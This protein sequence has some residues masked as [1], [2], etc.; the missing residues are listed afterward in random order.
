[1]LKHKK[2]IYIAVIAILSVLLLN[3]FSLNIFLLFNG[4]SPFKYKILKESSVCVFLQDN[5]EYTNKKGKIILVNKN[6]YNYCI[7]VTQK[8]YLPLWI[9]LSTKGKLSN[10]QDTYYSSFT[11]T[12]LTQYYDLDKQKYIPTYLI[13]KTFAINDNVECNNKLNQNIKTIICKRD[14]ITFIDL[15]SLFSSDVHNEIINMK[16]SDIIRQ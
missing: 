11:W 1:M 12:E 6:G 2:K 5:V 13:H 8:K 7:L 10:Q 3:I 4:Y 9:D 16:I 15:S 14:N